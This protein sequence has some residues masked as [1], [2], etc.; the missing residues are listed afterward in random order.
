MLAMVTALVFC[1][2]VPVLFMETLVRSLEKSAPHYP[3]YRNKSVYNGLGIV[4]SLWLLSFWSGA[5]LL[6]AADVDQPNWISYLIPIFP[7]IAGSCIFGLFDDWVGDRKAKGFRG[8]VGSL[9]RGI[10]TTGGLKM[11]AIGLLSLFTMV[12]LYWD[13]EGGVPRIIIGTCVIALS[14]NFINLFDL[15]PGRAGKVYLA[16]LGCCLL[17]VGFGGKVLLGWPDMVALVLAGLGPL[18]AVWRHD[19]G[20]RGMLGDAGANSMGA[21]LGYLLATAAPLWLLIMWLVIL[22]SLNLAGEYVSFSKI[23]KDNAILHKLD[24]LGRKDIVE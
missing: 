3:N 16:G 17:V 20:E 14:A 1:V 2:A 24:C 8:H 4:W 11:I 7:L 9:L 21:F 18:V 22:L 19:I 6:V 12:S 5:H 15:R 10:L 13:S 23:I